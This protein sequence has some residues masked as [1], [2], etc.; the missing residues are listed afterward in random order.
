V[1]G[2][3]MSPDEN[4]KRRGWSRFRLSTVVALMFVLAVAFAWGF[5]GFREEQRFREAIEAEQEAAKGYLGA[6]MTSVMARRGNP[7]E[8][9]EGHY[10]HPDLAYVNAHG[11]PITMI[12]N[13]SLGVLYLS[14][15]Q[16]NGQWVCF[17]A[18]YVREG[19]VF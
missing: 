13:D 14:F 17:S 4:T 9:W 12:Y 6:T 3:W 5:K 19:T 15:E 16:V 10:G 7:S 18:T 1:A 8:K 2:D 11:P